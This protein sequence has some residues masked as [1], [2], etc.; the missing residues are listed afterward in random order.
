MSVYLIIE[1]QTK[2]A[3]KYQQYIEKVY[4]LI[5]KFGGCYHVR[6]SDVQPLGD[7]KPE[8][9]IVVEFPSREHVAQWLA[10]DEYQAIAELREEGAIVRAVL[11]EGFPKEG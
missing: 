11:A 10:S 9:M 1:S 6:T 8:R 7:W 2:D 5:E 4:P 3:E